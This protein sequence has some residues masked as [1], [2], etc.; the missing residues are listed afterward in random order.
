MLTR[1][2]AST[3]YVGAKTMA[4]A[5]KAEAEYIARVVDLG[6][7]VCKRPAEYHHMLKGAGMGR[8]SSHYDGFGLCPDHHRN[9]GPGVAIHAG[10]KTW[11][12]KY[13]GELYWLGITKAELNC[14]H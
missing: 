8:K 2:C 14:D 6:C 11:E 13:G 9:G 4:R 3:R 5:T 1:R 12:A 10:V 7:V